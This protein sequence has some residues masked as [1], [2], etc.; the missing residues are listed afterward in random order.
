MRLEDYNFFSFP[1]SA[2]KHN[3]K[4]LHLKY[5]ARSCTGNNQFRSER[6]KTKFISLKESKGMSKAIEECHQNSIKGQILILDS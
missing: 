6:R 4:P 1:F 5:G 3:A 2:T